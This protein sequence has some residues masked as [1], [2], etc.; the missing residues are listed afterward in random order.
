MPDYVT[1]VWPEPKRIGAV[2][3]VSGWFNGQNTTDPIAE[4]ALEYF[5]DRAWHEIP[6]SRVRNN[7]RV[8]VV[9]E[10]AAID[11]GSIRLVV[12]RTPGNIARIWEVEFYLPN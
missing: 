8:E 2:R 1:F 12:T 7:A 10:F 5:E 11:A 3:I 6:G 9:Q 4:F